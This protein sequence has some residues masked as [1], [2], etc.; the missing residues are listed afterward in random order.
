MAIEFLTEKMEENEP[1][2]KWVVSL[3]PVDGGMAIKVDNPENRLDAWFLLKLKNDGTFY[4]YPSKEYDRPGENEA[5]GFE[6]NGQ[7]ELVQSFEE[8]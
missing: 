6:F 2:V 1:T 5:I 8:D 4:V 3:V 7:G